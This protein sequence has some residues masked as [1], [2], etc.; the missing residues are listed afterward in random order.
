MEGSI[1]IALEKNMA[2]SQVGV[3][4][5]AAFGLSTKCSTWYV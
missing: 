5:G 4:Y 1:E 2:L 3:D